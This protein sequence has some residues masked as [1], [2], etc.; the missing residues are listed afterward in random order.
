[1]IFEYLHSMVVYYAVSNVGEAVETIA[2]SP[3]GLVSAYDLIDGCG[4]TIKNK[5]PWKEGSD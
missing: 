4:V 1:M 2:I 5:A 3:V